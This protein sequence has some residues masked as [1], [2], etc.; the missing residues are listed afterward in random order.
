M[1]CT[2][3]IQNARVGTICLGQLSPALGKTASVFWA[4]LDRRQV[5][6]QRRFER[7]MISARWLINDAGR[8]AWSDPS[9]QLL[10]TG[11]GVGELLENPIAQSMAIEFVFGNVYANAIVD[12]LRYVLCLSSGSAILG[13]P[14][15]LMRRRCVITL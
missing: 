1:C 11:F 10:E 2:H 5:V 12:D 3:L 9:P 14:S 6:G 8:K 15:G 4:H 13:L 7:S